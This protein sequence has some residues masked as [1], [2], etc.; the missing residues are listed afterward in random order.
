R[1][2]YLPDHPDNERWTKHITL[3]FHNML[4]RWREFNHNVQQV[5]Y[6]MRLHGIGFAFFDKHGDWRFRSLETGNIL[7][8]R[9]SPS[10]LD[11]RI[12]YLFVRVPYRIVELWNRIKDEEAATKAGW[13]VPAVKGAIKYGMK[14]LIGVSDW[15]AQ[16]W[17]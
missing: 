1:T 3:R 17:E 14:G 7:A 11:K 8:P 16:P 12:P 9:G 6:W 15:Y 5:S 4:K 10:S 13:N 2:A